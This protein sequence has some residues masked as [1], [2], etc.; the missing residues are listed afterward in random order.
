LNEERGKNSFFNTDLFFPLP[1]L[2]GRRDFFKKVSSDDQSFKRAEDLF[3]II[4]FQ[5]HNL[6]RK[7]KVNEKQKSG[8]DDCTDNLS[9]D[10]RKEIYSKKSF[11][12]K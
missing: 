3:K 2:P 6:M 10:L 9:E 4:N 7:L 12:C 8:G 11:S 5:L 1:F